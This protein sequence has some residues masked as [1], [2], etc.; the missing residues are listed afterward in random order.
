MKNNRKLKK[1]KKKKKKEKKKRFIAMESGVF[2]LNFYL[3]KFHVSLKDPA[4]VSLRTSLVHCNRYFN[5]VAILK[6]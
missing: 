1:K 4:F 5:V 6:K 3:F 2:E